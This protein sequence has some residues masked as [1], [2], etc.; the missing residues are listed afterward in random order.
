MKNIHISNAAIEDDR[1]NVSIILKAHLLA[2]RY[3]KKQKIKYKMHEMCIAVHL[4]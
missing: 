1:L 2:S 4:L 3:E